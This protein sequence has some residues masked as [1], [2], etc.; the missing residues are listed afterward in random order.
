MIRSLQQWEHYMSCDKIP[1][2]T[3][4]K[5]LN[6]YLTLCEEDTSSPLIEDL[7]NNAA[8]WLKVS[9]LV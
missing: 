3:N 8:H 6:T 7:L 9:D 4:E 5:A 1:H 2:P